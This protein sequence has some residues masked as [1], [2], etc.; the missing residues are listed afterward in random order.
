MIKVF[1][2]VIF[3]TINL[4]GNK[5]DY[6]FEN[7]QTI[8]LVD[9]IKRLLVEN[10]T[11]NE[12]FHFLESLQRDINISNA[13]FLP[14]IDL[15]YKYTDYSK[16][17]VDKFT[18][19]TS[20]DITLRYN[21]FNG[22]E[23]SLNQKVVQSNYDTNIHL[24][25]QIESDLIYSLT[26]AFITIQKQK[27]ILELARKNLDDYDQ[28]VKKEDI[29]F[30][31]DLVSLRE[32]A[33][34][35]SRDT[36]QRMNFEELKKQYNDSIFT[37]QKYLDFN[38]EEIAYFEKLTPHSKY[39]DNKDIAYETSLSL[40]PYIQ[41]AKA[42]VVL[43]K[44]KMKQ[45]RVHFYPKV[46]LVGKVSR[47]DENYENRVADENKDKY[48]ALEAK[49]NF[50]SGGKD[51]STYEKRLS[52]YRQKIKKRDEVILDVKYKVN[53]SFSKYEFFLKKDK[54][55]LHLIKKREESY[56]GATYDYKF[57]KIDAD[58]LLDAVDDLY[59]AK[60]QY[61]TNK[62]DLQAVQYEILNNIG[63]IK[64]HILEDR[65]KE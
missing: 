50:Y 11:I 47:L 44:D 29:K 21:I 64:N 45:E 40:S 27:D 65:V 13:A 56:L 17:S 2:L 33:K 15:N 59:D 55:L 54:F 35:Q 41:E 43:S 36:I 32:Y 25:N 62:Y 61:I 8:Y 3:I 57:A 12:Q 63:V 39:L 23:D 42:N 53:L 58:I 37:F 20:K 9:F 60:K 46:D 10:P 48:V 52:E 38:K 4:Y 18:D 26:E 34:V 28:W 22:F 51:K 5:K 30:K 24:K 1:F 49:L 19:T 14:T 16:S 31:N 7:R 6:K